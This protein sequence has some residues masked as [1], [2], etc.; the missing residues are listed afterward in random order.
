MNHNINPAGSLSPAVGGVGSLSPAVRGAGSLSPAVGGVG[1]LSPAVG[2]AGSLSPAAGSIAWGCLLLQSPGVACCSASPWD[3]PVT[4]YEGEVELP[5]P[6]SWPGASIP[7]S[8]P[9]GPLPLS[10]PEGPLLPSLPR[11]LLR[12]GSLP[13]L[14]GSRKYCGQSPTKGSCRPRRRV[15]EVR[16]P[17][18]PQARPPPS[19]TPRLHVCVTGALRT[20]MLLCD[21]Y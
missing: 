21:G 3:P 20:P 15:G 6:P 5:L 12:L 19:R 14:N 1:S 2:G 10:P 4:E 16:R 7:S 11:V 18:P 13:V 9:E 17:P 8:P